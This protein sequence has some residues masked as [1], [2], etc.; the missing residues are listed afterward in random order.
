MVINAN[1]PLSGMKVPVLTTS[2]T[3]KAT[4]LQS[5]QFS[6]VQFTS[7]SMSPLPDGYW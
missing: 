3:A 2:H 5:V 7:S 6:S 4:A 1:L